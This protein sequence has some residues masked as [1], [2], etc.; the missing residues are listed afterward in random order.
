MASNLDDSRETVTKI[1]NDLACQI[2]KD[3]ARPGKKQ[4]YRCLNLHQICQ[5]CKMN[6]KK[7]SC[8]EPI[9]KEYCKQTEQLL[10]VK[11]LKL[12]CCN[13][14]NGCQ[15]VVN[16]SA[17][18]EHASKCVYRLVPCLLLA[19]NDKRCK[20][21]VTFKDA[22]QH[23]LDHEE[24]FSLKKADLKVKNSIRSRDLDKPA[25]P[26]RFLTIRPFSFSL[27]HQTFLLFMKILE[28]TV[29]IW[30]Y[31]V[32]SPEEAKHFAYTLKLFGN[33]VTHTTEGKVAAIDESF[34]ALF[35]AGKCFTI[36]HKGFIAQILEKTDKTCKFEYSLEIRNLKEEVKDENYESGISDNDEDIEKSKK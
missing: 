34:D 2:C 14:R 15:E 19:L 5:D 13:W 8:G 20:A 29:Y 31:I 26:D 21:K 1:R 24:G 7:C 16:E 35:N 12:N 18:E 25:T 4:W 23:F 6:S 10:S 33:E 32:G 22:I 9:S 30:I 28:N 11:R 27:N 3:P 36:S 17:L